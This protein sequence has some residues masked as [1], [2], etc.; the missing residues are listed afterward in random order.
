MH[1]DGLASVYLAAGSTWSLFGTVDYTMP[2]AA[3]LPRRSPDP[4]DQ[5][6]EPSF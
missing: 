1:F 4:T 6:K 5:Q 2:T 3:I